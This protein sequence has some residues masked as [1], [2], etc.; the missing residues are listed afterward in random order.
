MSYIGI[1]DLFKVLRS[2]T[3]KSAL[4]FGTLPLRVKWYES[5]EVGFSGGL[6]S[7]SSHYFTRTGIEVVRY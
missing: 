6:S 5:C 1:E 2:I 4:S 3:R 7:H